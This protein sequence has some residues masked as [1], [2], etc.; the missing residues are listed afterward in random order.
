[1]DQ[2]TKLLLEGRNP[3][4]AAAY[5]ALLALFTFGWS[6]PDELGA[7]CN[8]PILHVGVSIF[9]GFTLLTII[10]GLINGFR[11]LLNGIAAVHNLG[12]M[13]RRAGR[14]SSNINANS[15]DHSTSL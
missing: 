6:Y 8:G 2:Q 13:D 3:T 12:A 9:V 4:A 15:S 14:S 11:H 7:F 1:M 10:I 5:I